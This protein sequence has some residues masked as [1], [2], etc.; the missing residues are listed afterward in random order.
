MNIKRYIA[1]ILLVLFSVLS[2]VSCSPSDLL[3]YFNNTDHNPDD[4]SN[5]ENNSNEETEPKELTY[6]EYS[7]LTPEEKYEYL[8][9]FATV[10]DF[11]DWYNAAK[12]KYDEEQNKDDIEIGE[13]GSVDIG[14]DFGG[15]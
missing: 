13:G 5:E 3:V 11:L 6:E 9:S 14:K 7:A 2:V 1:L 8:N 10:Q 12:A 15:N 4:D